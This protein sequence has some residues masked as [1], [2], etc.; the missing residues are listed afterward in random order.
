MSLVV[1]V[2]HKFPHKHFCNF[3]LMVVNKSYSDMIC[4]VVYQVYMSNQHY[5]SYGTDFGVY[6]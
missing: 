1:I 5:M 3:A 4:D 2:A 6:M